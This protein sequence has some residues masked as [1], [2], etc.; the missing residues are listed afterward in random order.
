MKS[1]AV[2]VRQILDELKE[3]IPKFKKGMVFET[4]TTFFPEENV[5]RE[6]KNIITEEIEFTK[7]LACCRKDKQKYI[8]ENSPIKDFHRETTRGDFL[9]VVKVNKDKGIAFCINVSLKE[10]IGKKYYSEEFIPI[11]FEDIFSGKVKIYRR[12]IEKFFKPKLEE[13][14]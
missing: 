4:L 3:T 2:T 6:F 13:K 11:T 7:P 10:E 5:K 9:K 14:A 1:S 12:N 8:K